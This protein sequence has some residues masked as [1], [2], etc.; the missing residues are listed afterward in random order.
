MTVD[1]SVQQLVDRY[2]VAM[3][4]A[5]PGLVQMLY[6]TGSVALGDYRP[7]HS[8]VD[9]LAVTGRTLRDR[10]LDIVAAIHAELPHRPHLDGVYLDRAALAREPDDEPVQ[11][12]VLQGVFHADQHC[13]ELNPVLWLT[14]ARY[15]ITVRG[16]RTASLGLRTDRA[17]LTRWNLDNLTAYWVPLAERMQNRMAT[18]PGDGPVDSGIVC[19]TVLGPARLHY[20][21]STGDVTS[22]SRAG[23]Y[24]AEHFPDWADLADRSVSYRHGRDVTFTASDAVA[25]AALTMAVVRDAWTRWG[26]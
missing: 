20:T 18:R 3:D 7:P 10:E 9:F 11:P 25:A 14:L 2:L 4:A 6:L 16:P 22:K 8:D 24:V 23:R 5:L 26:G 15:G 1:A 13:G 17:R 12:H 19:W 21:L